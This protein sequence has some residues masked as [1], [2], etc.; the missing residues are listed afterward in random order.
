M[1]QVVFRIL[2]PLDVQVD[3]RPVPLSGARQRTILAMLLLSANHVVSVDTLA[4][5]VWQGSPPTTFVNQIAICVSGLRKAF[6]AAVGADDLIV[7]SHPGYL[8]ATGAHRIDAAEFEELVAEARDAR[9]RGRTAAAAGLLEQALGL[10]RGRALEGVAAGRVAAEA[11]R[12]DEQRLAVHEEFTALRLDLG[13]HRELIGELTSFLAEHGLR[14]QARAQL[15]L[16]QYRSGLRAEALETYREARRLFAEELGIEPGPRLRQLHDAVLA[17][18]AWL[19]APP[20]GPA[21]PHP[22]QPHPGEMY[23]GDPHAGDPQPGDPQPGAG[24]AASAEPEAERQGFRFAFEPVSQRRALTRPAGPAAEHRP[25]RTSP[26]PART[27]P[28]PAR[29]RA[30]DRGARAD[31]VPPAR[32]PQFV[33][34]ATAALE[35]RLLGPVEATAGG[36]EIPL[37][38]AK[39]RSVL[40]ALLLADGRLLPDDRLSTLIWG[41][42][43]PA[44]W[45]AQL[46]TYASRLRGRLGPLVDLVRRGP[47]YRLDIGPARLDLREFRRDADLGHRALENGAYARAAELL[48]AALGQ[49]RGEPLTGVTPQ[50]AEKELPA[51]EESRLA[52]LEDRIEAELALG[53]HRA[54]VPELLR[55]VA[56]HPTRERLRGQLMIGLYRCDRQGD[57]LEVYEAGRRLLAEDLGVDPGPALRRLHHQVLTGD[58]SHPGV[59]DRSAAVLTPTARPDAEPP[60]TTRP[61]VAAPPGGEERGGLVPAMLPPATADFIGRERHLTALAAALRGVRVDG[62]ATGAAVEDPAAPV[63][64]V[65]LTGGAGTG[66]S[67]LAVH[68][69]HLVRDDFPDGHLYADLSTPDGTPRDPGAVLGGFLRALGADRPELPDALDERVRLYRS[70]LAGRHVLVVLDNAA[71]DRQ[72]RPLLTAESRSRT[73]VTSRAA[74]G[75]LE[76]ARRF[77]VGPLDFPGAYQLLAAAGRERVSADPAATARIVELCERLP[78]A[79]RV[80]AARLAAHPHWSPARLADRL[81]PAEHRL[82]EL[83]LDDLDV[84]AR[85]GSGLP[86][87]D[88]VARGALGVLARADADSWTPADAAALLGSSERDAEEVLESLTGARL[89]TAAE[90]RSELRYRFAPL[91]RLVAL[92]E[93]RTAVAV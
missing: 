72:V 64:P 41:W 12:L 78:L 74:L 23:P 80:C 38:G 66:K 39:Q 47:G 91:V 18:E 54:A 36:R 52:V 71:D 20:A 26:P 17:D 83:R 57:A 3:G 59:P 37:D 25:A 58:L 40:A 11:A 49:W 60:G 4:E 67:A 89:L 63:G 93:C 75:V 92:E 24:A 28:P 2:G 55:L 16:A 73:L 65:V 32:S 87:L 22:G 90:D 53:G 44:T 9:Q 69:A 21:T 46:H 86:G 6:K 33:P 48:S 88:P 45:T 68:A 15:M 30:A 85:L 61:I 14:E 19:A 56:E 76:G 31:E 42:D 51:L 5:A 84:R 50:L 82:D 70:R 13:R 29:T 43:P 77:Q 8:L 10:W 34:A 7:T 79:L 35:F 62:P 1:L 27:S 81:T